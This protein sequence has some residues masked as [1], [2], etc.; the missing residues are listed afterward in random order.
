MS[1][2]QPKGEHT[3]RAQVLLT[4]KQQRVIDRAAKA[5]NMSRSNFMATAST[6]A[7]EKTLAK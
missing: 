5:L 7:A 2:R 3:E 6:A 1:A 4:E